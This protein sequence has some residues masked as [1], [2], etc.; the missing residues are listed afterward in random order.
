MHLILPCGV[1]LLLRPRPRSTCQC[2]GCATLICVPAA[3][4]RAV[5]QAERFL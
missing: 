4:A 2:D 3:V 5:G 1:V